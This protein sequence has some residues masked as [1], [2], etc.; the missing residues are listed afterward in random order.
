MENV[1]GRLRSWWLR[2]GDPTALGST[3]AS[4]WWTIALLLGG[5]RLGTLVQM[6][7]SF[8][9]ALQVPGPTALTVLAWLLAAVWSVVFCT[10]L[11]RSRQP[12]G[13]RLV[14]V[15]VAVVVVLIAMGELTVPVSDRIGSWIGFQPGYALSVLMA[16]SLIPSWRVWALAVL[17]VC[18]SD[19]RF[20]MADPDATAPTVAGNLLTLVLMPLL[21]RLAFRYATRIALVADDSKARSALLARREEERRAQAA[22]HNGAAVMELLARDDL[23]EP[24]KKALREQAREETRR[25]RRYLSGD[26]GPVQ[27]DT[28]VVELLE[29]SADAFPDL[30]IDLITDLGLGLEVPEP[31]A[32]ALSA[33]VTSVL[34]NV[35]EHSGA[36]R[37]VVHLDD[38]EAF[39]TLSVHDDGAG[40]DVSSTPEGVG[41][42]EVVRHA[43][44]THGIHVRIDSVLGAGTNV[45]I[46]GARSVALP[47]RMSTGVAE[48]APAPLGESA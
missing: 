46:T 4:L 29:R 11:W 7:P 35:R 47:R 26:T 32:E 27:C 45:V 3:R 18:A 13:T 1:G 28:C 37:V 40:F 12:P 5:L 21:T 2:I 39:W 25:M 22:M 9:S 41:L 33:A 48:R 17:A 8:P 36:R 44:S 19:L 10:L 15:D 42:R 34:L 38:G 24:V 31:V 43:L 23:S 30:R 14:V 6:A 16:A 20:I